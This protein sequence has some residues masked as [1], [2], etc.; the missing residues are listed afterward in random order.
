MYMLLLF[1]VRRGAYRRFRFSSDKTLKCFAMQPHKAK[2]D[3]TLKKEKCPI[4]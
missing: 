1:E 4:I 3:I 2:S